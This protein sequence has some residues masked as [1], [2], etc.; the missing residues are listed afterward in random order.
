VQDEVT[1]EILA[2]NLGALGIEKHLAGDRQLAVAHESVTHHVQVPQL[3]Q[4]LFTLVDVGKLVD[5]L[6]GLLAQPQRIALSLGVDVKLF[7]MHWQASLRVVVE[8]ERN[9]SR[10][11]K[12]LY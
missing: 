12:L 4:L 2:H 10:F 1:V 7:G 6:N 9:S 8:P 3:H 5:H 11:Y